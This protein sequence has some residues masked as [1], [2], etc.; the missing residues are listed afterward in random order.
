M[1]ATRE[2]N[3]VDFGVPFWNDTAKRFDTDET[4]GNPHFTYSPTTNV[5]TVGLAD[6]GTN[7]T[8][9][10]FGYTALSSGFLQD[11]SGDVTVDGAAAIALQIN[12]TSV[13][14]IAAAGVSLATGATLGWTAGGTTVTD[15]V[16]TVAVTGASDD[17]LVTEAAVRTAIDNAIEED[18]TSTSTTVDASGSS[19]VDSETL[20]EGGVVWYYVVEDGS[21]YRMGQ[22][23]AVVGD[24][25]GEVQFTEMTTS[26]IGDTSNITF[27]V[28]YDGTDVS[29]DVTNAG[30][31]WDLLLKKNVL[32][33]A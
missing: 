3:P 21:N 2:D 20:A 9:A 33:S 30:G 32:V 25:N 22:I 6:V 13:L 7:G 29:L 4:D 31:T 16:T 19:T 18:N 11:S 8:D 27:N 23:M 15:I 1:V 28:T 12:E 5:L 24:A 10:R 26:D 17:N 14:D